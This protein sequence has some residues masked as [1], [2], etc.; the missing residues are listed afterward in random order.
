MLLLSLARRLG[1][2]SKMLRGVSMILLL[3]SML[4]LLLVVDILIEFIEIERI[5]SWEV[6][7]CGG[8]RRSDLIHVHACI[9]SIVIA[10][11]SILKSG[12]HC[13]INGLALINHSFLKS[14]H[15]ILSE[16]LQMVWCSSLL[17]SRL[18]Y[19]RLHLLLLLN[20]DFLL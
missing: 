1:N 11:V 14:G 20:Y 5:V 18:H 8:C 2:F 16:L 19:L 3:W 12:L 9:V 17:C 6:R 7:L 15:N 10:H 13:F 4:L